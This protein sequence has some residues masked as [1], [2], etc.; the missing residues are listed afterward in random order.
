MSDLE[1][2]KNDNELAKFDKLNIRNEMLVSGWDDT[3]DLIEE[4]DD[5]HSDPE[6]GIFI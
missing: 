3:D 2:I 6:R 4:D 1:N 5:P